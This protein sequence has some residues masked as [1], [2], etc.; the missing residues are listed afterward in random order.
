MIKLFSLLFVFSAF[1][2]IADPLSR[3]HYPGPSS[4][5]YLDID[6]FQGHYFLITLGS[7]TFFTSDDAEN[8]ER[9]CAPDLIY[10]FAYGNGLYVAVG[11][12]GTI[13]TSADAE[14]WTTATSNTSEDLTSIIFDG[15]KFYIAGGATLVRGDGVTWTPFD[16]TLPITFTDVGYDGVHWVAVG[17]NGNFWYTMNETDWT[18]EIFDAQAANYN[19]SDVVSHEGSWIFTTGQGTFTG[20]IGGSWSLDNGKRSPAD[21]AMLGDDLLAIFDGTIFQRNDLGQYTQGSVPN[22][23]LPYGIAT[24][25]SSVVVAGEDTFIGKGPSIQTIDYVNP[26]FNYSALGATHN[27]TTVVRYGNG[28]F[29]STNLYEWTQTDSSF[30]TF[31]YWDGSRF[32]LYSNSGTVLT[33]T[34]GSSWTSTPTAFNGEIKDMHYDGSIYVAVGSFG[35]ASAANPEDLTIRSITVQAGKKGGNFSMTHV[36]YNGSTFFAGGSDSPLTLSSSDGI[37]WNAQ[38]R[39][40]NSELTNLFFFRGK[41]IDW[42]SSTLFYSD[43][44]I[45]WFFDNDVITDNNKTW[46]CEHGCLGAPNTS[47]TVA[48]LSDI[49]PPVNTDINITFSYTFL[50]LDSGH[51]FIGARFIDQIWEVRFTLE[52]QL[53]NWPETSILD[54]ID[55]IIRFADCPSPG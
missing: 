5:S 23:T 11:R 43:D 1:Q 24:D 34:D 35:V 48:L 7:E 40:D 19:I 21:F 16:L 33:S 54:W 45:E 25:G 28:V 52:S 49:D 41:L 47:G 51:F 44:G 30:V 20:T 18:L 2:L 6:Y 50:C 26:P 22:N 17:T 36:A 13:F 15:T 8:W 12:N 37:T 39:N 3:I 38:T 46:C 55:Q 14:T 10:D 42:D 9:V 4:E 32:I 53:S 29:T 27:G 31:G